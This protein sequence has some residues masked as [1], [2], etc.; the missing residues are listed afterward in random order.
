MTSTA[1]VS[2]RRNSSTSSPVNPGAIAALTHRTLQSTA[3]GHLGVPPRIS[4]W[5]RLGEEL[6]QGAREP[7]QPLPLVAYQLRFSCE[8]SLPKGS[9]SATGADGNA[10][11]IEGSIPFGLDLVRIHS[12]IA[13]VLS[14][15]VLHALRNAEERKP[16]P[17]VRARRDRLVRVPSRQLNRDRV[18][19]GDALGL[20]AREQPQRD[21]ARARL[22][23]TLHDRGTDPRDGR[24]RTLEV[25]V[26]DERHLMPGKPYLL[27][28]T[29]SSQGL[30]VGRHAGPPGS[31]LVSVRFEPGAERGSDNLSTLLRLSRQRDSLVAAACAER[32]PPCRSGGQS[33]RC[34]PM[35]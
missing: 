4:V 29:K 2:D 8:V 3:G 1:R 11:C 25:P 10:R 6:A 21:V 27:A 18:R 35:S 28:A 13:V 20:V 17:G 33:S 5:R 12:A 34:P 15:I 32:S 19:P 26:V 24:T 22:T 7:A 23:R 14:S 16:L 31:S 9:R 30:R